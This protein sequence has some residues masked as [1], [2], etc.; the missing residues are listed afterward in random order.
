MDIISRFVAKEKGITRYFTGNAC[1][2]GHLCERE[3]SSGECVEC[4]KVR[5]T[6]SKY[7]GSQK[8]QQRRWSE[9]NREKKN[10]LSRESHKRCN[11]E[12]REFCTISSFI[13]NSLSRIITDYKGTRGKGESL[14]GYSAQQLKVHI[15]SLWE[16]GMSW[17]NRT[18]WHIDHIKSVKSFKDERIFDP[19]VVNAL[20][21]LQPLWA[22]DNLRKGG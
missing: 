14:C 9:E 13:R 11:P 19:K 6:S 1:R 20:S 18:E 10:R 17:E 12:G 21:N 5:R 16:E 2:R 7:K 3:T 4:K 22:E 15:E 8:L